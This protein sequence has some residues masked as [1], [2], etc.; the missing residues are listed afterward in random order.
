MDITAI[1]SEFPSLAPEPGGAAT[2]FFD[3]AAGTQVPRRC[4]DRMV[5]YL[6]TSNANTHGVFETSRRSDAL[7]EEAR[8]AMADLVGA[9]DPREIA[10]GANMTTLTQSFAR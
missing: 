3:N 7:I 9:T 5:D 1:R 2:I 6:T 10:F 4:I 8:A